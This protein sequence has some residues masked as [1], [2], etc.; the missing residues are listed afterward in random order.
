MQPIEGSVIACAGLGS[1]LGMGMPKCLIEIGGCTILT[2]LIEMLRPHVP[3]IHVV[4][5]Y[6]EELVIDHCARHHPDVVLVRNPNFRD[7]TTVD[8]YRLG[9]IGFHNKVLFLDGDL[10]INEHSFDLFL[11]LAAAKELLIGVTPAK[12]SQPV[13]VNT[14][15]NAQEGAEEVLGF[16]RGQKTNL[17]WANLFCGNPAILNAPNDYVYECLEKFLPASGRCVELFEIDTLEDL[18]R[19]TNQLPLY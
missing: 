14:R 7:T 18:S 8:S 11:A 5:G 12:S 17:E 9:S 1:R 10:I 16:H 4:I 15:A 6:R 13:F 19:A 3:R 2:R